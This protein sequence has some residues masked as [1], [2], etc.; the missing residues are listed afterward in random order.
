MRKKRSK[1]IVRIFLQI[2]CRSSRDVWN[3]EASTMSRWHFV[4]SILCGFN[5]PVQQVLLC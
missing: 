2:T 4:Q 5:V 1:A 3:R